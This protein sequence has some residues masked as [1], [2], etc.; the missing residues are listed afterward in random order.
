MST[1]LTNNSTLSYLML[2]M[3]FHLM[4]SV[5]CKFD[6]SKDQDQFK[7]PTIDLT[8]AS[9]ERFEIPIKTIRYVEL[10]T[11]PDILIGK[12]TRIEVSD[13]SFLIYDRASN[14]ILNFGRDGRFQCKIDGVGKGPGE[15]LTVSNL[16]LD[17]ESRQITL[18]DN[19]SRSFIKGNMH[20]GDLTTYQWPF[21]F[22]RFVQL[23]ADSYVMY[24]FSDRG[25]Q[26]NYIDGW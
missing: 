8:D 4:T 17:E 5:G 16:S 10:E 13:Q 22:T 2:A 25:W 14:A 20:C 7:G 9:Q 3:V 18:A 26:S 24:S 21:L 11:R 12:I 6:A 15:F 23:G 1:L 19:Q